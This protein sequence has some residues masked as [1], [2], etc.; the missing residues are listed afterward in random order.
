M[1][2]AKRDGREVPFDRKRIEN[3]V[4]AAMKN[5]SG[6]VDEDVAVR[7]AESIEKKVAAGGISPMPIST[8]EAMVFDELIERGHRLTAKAY[9]GYRRIHEFQRVKNTVDDAV[10]G[11]V[12]QS[13]PDKV[14]ENSNK[15]ARVNATQRDLIAGEFSKDYARRNLIPADIVQAH[16]EGII[17]FHD[18]DYFIQPMINCCLVNLKDM[19]EKG[20]VINGKLIER[21]KSLQTAATL[22]TQ[23]VQQIASGQYGGQTISIAHL[24]P[25]VRVSLERHRREAA[26]DLKEMNPSAEDIERVAQN[27]LA[28]EVK[29]AIQTI[30]YQINT[31]NTGN[32][33][34]PFLSIFMY[35]NEEP[36]YIEETAMLI[37][38]MLRQRTEGMKNA[39]GAYISPAFPKL[40]YVLDENNVPAGSRYRYLTDE[41]C[42]CVAKRM[43]PDFISAKK[44]KENYQGQ[45]FGPMGCVDG[46]EVIS[47]R[48]DGQTHIESFRRMWHRLANRFDIKTQPGH[49]ND[50]YIDLDG[51]DI[52]DHVNGWTECKRIIRNANAEMLR[53]TFSNGRI[54]TCTP[55]HPFE[56]ENRGIVPAQNLLPTDIIRADKDSSMVHGVLPHS[57]DLAWLDGLMLCD[58][59]YDRHLS[60]SVAMT[61]EDEI[62]QRFINI[63]KRHFQLDTNVVEQHRKRKGDY[64]DL[65]IR[66]DGT[67][68][69]VNLQCDYIAR[70]GGIKKMDRHIPS[71]VFAWNRSARLAFLAGM[72]DADGYVNDHMRIPRIQIGSTNKELA[73]QQLMLAQSLGMRGSIYHNH[74][75]GQGRSDTLRYRVEF[76][77]TAEL[78][79]RIVCEK[80]KAKFHN[81]KR[82]NRSIALTDNCS[83]TN[84]EC[85]SKR[86]FSYDV[87]TAS[88]HFTVSGIYSHNCRSF[89]SPYVNKKGEFQ[90]YGRFN[91]GVVTLNL[92]DVALS[93]DRDIDRF[94]KVLDQR[95]DLCYRALMVRHEALLGTVS[96]VSP[97]H[98]Q[99]G[100]LAR[101][102]PGEKIDEMLNSRYSTLSLGYIGLSEAVTALTGKPHTEADTRELGLSIMR[103]LR[104]ACDEWK[105]DT[106]FGF[107]L[108]GTPA[109]ST[110]YKFAKALQKRF[111]IVPGI[112]DHLYITNS[113]HVNVRQPI[114]PF[115]K[116]AFES[117]FQ[118]ISSGG[119]IS[120]IEVANMTSNIDAIKT[121]VDFMYD[122][123]Q[124]AE[125]NTKSDYCQKCG[126]DGEIFLD[127]NLDWK[128]PNC[129]NRDRQFLNVTRR[130]CGYLGDNFW[131]R[132]RT[133]EIAERFVHLDNRLYQV[134]R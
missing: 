81:T 115:E 70:F 5:G 3:A 112:T 34:S 20:T 100:G 9:E 105:E 59:C 102:K 29:A 121:L 126:F 22:A 71:E 51:V 84:I 86:T 12:R 7:T 95:L 65:Y 122:T 58:G 108:Y 91:Q 90:F 76:V 68:T 93:S 16:D 124:Y 111:G 117:Q 131:N 88:E 10:M 101:L 49:T 123:I 40:L 46:D 44:M 130:T 23:I 27:R 21:P 134:N 35:L 125:I 82:A 87:T 60:V 8:I 89:L 32:G 26:E 55:D 43:M 64:K 129:G 50:F 72:I 97:I 74:Y 118:D 13:D 73:L 103:R 41:A 133:Q 11:I 116:L 110:T 36:E 61:G 24:S 99:H 80:K 47:Y 128:C 104:S 106:G 127:E 39:K 113:Y 37:R 83:M 69:V 28:R 4:R 14:D 2:V 85:C 19:F 42:V 79:D 45:V 67:S 54:L 66:S 98:W 48:L 92:V 62:E 31:F 15:N 33:Q 114:G 6:I 25:F 119:A 132:G 52:Y 17:H 120:Y 109:E 63:V 53:I 96:D 75:R 57:E 38:E 18:M 30:Q 107:A 78:I 1:K 77:P 94:W 56:T